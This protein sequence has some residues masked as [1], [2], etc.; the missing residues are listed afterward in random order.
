MAELFVKIVNMS[1]TATYVLAAVLVLRLILNRAPKWI[2]YALWSLVLFRLVCPVSISSTFSI[3]GGLGKSA[4]TGGGIEYI[5]ANIGMMAAP[6][7]DIGTASV[8]TVIN[9][10]L[11]AATPTASVSPMQILVFIGACIWLTGIAVMLIYSIVSYL[12]LRHRMAEATLLL[13][14]NIFETDKISSPFV[15]GIL[16]PRIYLPV[17]L[18]GNGRDYVLRHEQTHIVR[19]DHLIKPFAFL[20]LSVH[21]FNPFI[22][23]SFFLMSR[24]LEMS[25]DEKV[26]S[27]LD[28]EGK[29]GYSLALMQFAMKRPIPAGSPL[30]FGESGAKG[31]I[32]NVLNYKKPAFW[33]LI[34]A[35]VIVITAG[36]IL[37]T[38][39]VDKAPSQVFKAE[40][41]SDRYV[42]SWNDK[43]YRSYGFL[44]DNSGLI[45]EK[46]ASVD[47]GYKN[48]CSIYLVNGYEPE[49]WIIF[50]ESSF[51]GTYT[52]YKEDSV[53][54]TPSEFA[55][56]SFDEKDNAISFEEARQQVSFTIFIPTVVPAELVANN[57]II[58]I[59]EEP[60]N[61]VR[62]D[63]P[64]KDGSIGLTVLNGPV[65][66][67]LAV[68]PRK[69][70]ETINI[71]NDI[72]AHYL[73]NQP[74]FDG[75][76]LWWEE[77]GSYVAL[78]SPNLS[79][80]DLV[81][82]AESMSPIADS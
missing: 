16:R 60:P 32:R 2:S 14:G 10:A 41:A 73:S 81:Q 28:S 46:F 6:Q 7:A 39:P 23:L 70:G 36:F 68:D 82:L 37:L 19:K 29:T 61:Y 8:N 24:D 43:V 51:M 57:L 74:E 59:D 49:Q 18:S 75:L 45:G 1:I 72:E 56:L 27:S 31:R 50:S 38:D 30:A 44:N 80:D 9:G 55:G 33:I 20:V 67:G 52:L 63:Y 40:L 48:S 78:L 47:T 64:A 17:G 65:G 22:W 76:I 71:R 79:K 11:P 62:V 15:C 34:V 69:E 35:V 5:P 42:L 53:T 21:W 58:T 3:F 13:S 4:S 66:S 26:I 12:R 54:E 25:C 77:A